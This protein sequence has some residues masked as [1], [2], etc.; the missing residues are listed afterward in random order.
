MHM[1]GCTSTAPASDD[2][3]LTARLEAIR[4]VADRISDSVAVMDREF[5]LIYA[6]KL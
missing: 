3:I 2:P 5:N 1:A 4:Q 6:N